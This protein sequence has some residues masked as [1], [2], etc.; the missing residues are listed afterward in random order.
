MF[1]SEEA[2]SGRGMALLPGFRGT[3]NMIIAVVKH[4]RTISG[5]KN[6]FAQ[7]MWCSYL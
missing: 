4:L 5:S 7:D 6:L 3:I 1:T 2:K